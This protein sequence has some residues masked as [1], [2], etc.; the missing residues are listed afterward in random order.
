[1]LSIFYCTC[2]KLLFLLENG[3]VKCF[4]YVTFLFDLPSSYMLDT[5]YSFVLCTF[6][7]IKGLNVSGEKEYLFTKWSRK[8]II[9]SL[10]FFKKNI[11]W[12]VQASVK[13]AYKSLHSIKL[14]ND[15]LVKMPIFR[16]QGVQWPIHNDIKTEKSHV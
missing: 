14:R 12:G 2:S 4:D 3:H 7:D 6:L 1:M 13:N 16:E 10:G 11:R 5:K 8:Y 15:Y 9:R